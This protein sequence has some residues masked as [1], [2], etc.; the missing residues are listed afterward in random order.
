MVVQ[1]KPSWATHLSLYKEENSSEKRQL[2]K[3]LG[4][5]SIELKELLEQFNM[6]G[7]PKEITRALK[8][9]HNRLATLY[10]VIQDKFYPQTKLT[11]F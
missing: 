6:G 11:D 1:N 3:D 5:I 2:L 4:D 8:S 9:V 7:T 10:R